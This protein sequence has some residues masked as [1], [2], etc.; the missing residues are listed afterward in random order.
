MCPPP[1]TTQKAEHRPLSGMQN[2]AA[3]DEPEDA[4]ADEKHLARV[5]RMTQLEE[6]GRTGQKPEQCE[7]CRGPS[8][9]APKGIPEQKEPREHLGRYGD[10]QR[11]RPDALRQEQT[12]NQCERKSGCRGSPVPRRARPARRSASSPVRSARRWPRHC[13][14]RAAHP[15]RHKAELAARRTLRLP[16]QEERCRLFQ[17]ICRPRPTSLHGSRPASRLTGARSR[18]RSASQMST[19][20]SLGTKR[21]KC[22]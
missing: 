19:T 14:T 16:P 22:D 21:G 4:R 20:A 1:E 5:R 9:D 11:E 13:S 17:A 8:P 3:R 10:P 12:G 15:A 2:A 18:R 6:P 7:M